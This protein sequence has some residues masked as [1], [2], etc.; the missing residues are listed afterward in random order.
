[1]SAHL[2]RYLLFEICV[3]GTV[4][5]NDIFRWYSETF[6][7]R[8]PNFNN[9]QRVDQLTTLT[10]ALIRLGL[11]SLITPNVTNHTVAIT[12][13]GNLIV[14]YSIEI[15]TYNLII[16]NLAGDDGHFLNVQRLLLFVS[17]FQE[18]NVI[19]YHP[20]DHGFF[21]NYNDSIPHFPHGRGFYQTLYSSLLVA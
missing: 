20:R 18:F 8:Q 12:L 14:Y 11:N 13:S 3:G 6:Y 17:G 10:N 16:S 15:E 1:M 7:V 21:Q 5:E 9:Q 4:S 2:S 19:Q